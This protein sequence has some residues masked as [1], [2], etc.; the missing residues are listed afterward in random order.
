MRLAYVHILPLEYY[1]P[2]TNAIRI[3]AS[4]DDVDAA[5]W[6]SANRKSL[7]EF[8]CDGVRIHR[9]PFVN[10]GTSA[11]L[12]FYQ[13]LKWH[14][15]CAIALRK[16][17]PDA[18]LYI[19]PHS[20]IA[21]WIY[22]RLLGGKARLFIH[23]HEYYAPHDYDRPGMKLVKLGQKA[24]QSELFPRAE[25]ISQTNESRSGFL[26]K[27]NPEIAAEKFQI[28]P[29]YPPLSWNR[30]STQ[31]AI[32]GPVRLLYLGSASFHDTYIRELVEWVARFPDKATLTISG[33]NVDPAV[34]EW[35]EKENFPNVQTF[36]QGWQYD[37][38]PERLHNYDVGL[39]LY[40]GN[41]LNFVYNAPN[42]LFE[43]WAAG[44]EVWYPQEMKQITHL[45][46]ATTQAPLRRLDFNELPTEG[47]FP[48]PA[49]LR[50]FR[51]D[52]SCENA[53]APLLRAF[54]L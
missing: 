49:A 18:I 19:E 39:I 51:S 5:V 14:W 44:L 41:T 48:R 37:E 22:Y 9:L 20:A 2:A 42:K 45:Q 38:L 54:D 35:L 30:K 24:E 50:E 13:C 10:P 23:H 15:D 17:K 12:R 11:F 40:R 25:W 27:D 21:A 32:N 4:M 34:W 3:F 53:I 31:P 1:P 29:N 16:F 7:P 52:Y 8:N 43:Y 28:W 26:A 36:P 6:T 47:P 46:E 33:F